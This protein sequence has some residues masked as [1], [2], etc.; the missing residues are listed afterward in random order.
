MLGM[1]RARA[2]DGTPPGTA[3][4][5]GTTVVVASKPDTE[6]AILGHMIGLL[7]EQGG[8]PVSYRIGYGTT[9]DIR[10]ALMAGRIDIYPEYTGNAGL[11]HAVPADPAWKA[12]ATALARARELDGPQGVVWLTPAPASNAWAI[13]VRREIAG[14]NRDPTLEDFARWVKTGGKVKLAA[15]NEFLMNPL[16]LPAFEKAYGFTLSQ[17]QIMIV[18]GGDTA[19]TIRAA[20]VG[21]YGV[22]AA[23]VY[24]TDGGIAA[25]GLKLLRDT[26]A[27]Q[28]VY[29][30]AP[31]TRAEVLAARPGLPELLA[32]AFEG[33]SQDALQALNAQV[34]FENREPRAVAETYLRGRGLL[35]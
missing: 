11:F 32:P 35:H 4:A 17:R 20:A 15:S 7:L 8:V 1:G 28:P 9:L 24:G 21:K 29:Q 16:A 2:G 18:S 34:Q 10:A 26:R 30:P 23:M 19:E 12:P 31:V 6:G 14:S 22:N 25:M 5:A 27:V 33:L 13:A 3:Q